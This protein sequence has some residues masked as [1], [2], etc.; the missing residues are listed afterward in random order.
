MGILSVGLPEL[1][2]A[3][4]EAV[5][6]GIVADTGRRPLHGAEVVAVRSK[7]AARSDAKGMFSL[8]VPLG[9]ETFLIRSPGYHP[10]AFQATFVAGDTLRIGIV[11]GSAPMV[12]PELVVVAENISY[13]GKM[14]GFATRMLS[15][16][17]PRSSFLTRADIERLGLPRLVDHLLSTGVK[18]RRDRRG[19]D[20]V[21]CAHGRT[22]R[23]KVAYYIDGALVR[24]DL[25]LSLI[26]VG[27]VEGIE[28]YKSA[29]ELPVQFN[30]SGYDCA[31]VV[32]LK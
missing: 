10:E 24:E 5:L 11:L 6:F 1:A 2:D 8:L 14:T 25:D 31:V 13:R 28:V 29:A 18:L 30:Q 16:G 21:E 9:D 32:W 4:R 12:L 27:A 3:Q 20:Y 26:D 19:R 15:S 22:S 7:R 17:A 23:P